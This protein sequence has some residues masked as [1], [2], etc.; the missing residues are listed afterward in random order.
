MVAIKQPRE[1]CSPT[2]LRPSRAEVYSSASY[3]G[4]RSRCRRVGTCGDKGRSPTTTEEPDERDER[5]ER[6][7]FVE[8]RAESCARNGNVWEST[9]GQSAESRLSSRPDSGDEPRL[10]LVGAGG[11]QPTPS[12]PEAASD[13]RRTPSAATIHHRGGHS[14]FRNSSRSARSSSESASPKVWPQLPRPG[15]VVSYTRRVSMS[16]C[17][18][19]VSTAV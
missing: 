14:V 11:L 18:T 10:A 1:Q 6:G 17:P 2:A 13:R 4:N 12:R 16:P 5:D 15:T 8:D 9:L 19:G 7:A 3:R